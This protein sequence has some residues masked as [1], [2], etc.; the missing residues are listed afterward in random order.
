MGQCAAEC[1]RYVA[2]VGSIAEA[3]HAN[4]VMFRNR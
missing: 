1:I 2:V 4:D 3:Y